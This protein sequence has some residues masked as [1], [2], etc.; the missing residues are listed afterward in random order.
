VLERQKERGKKENNAG[1]WHIHLVVYNLP[2]NL[3]CMIHVLWG[4]GSISVK[5]KSYGYDSAKSAAYMSKYFIKDAYEIQK[6]DK[7]YL[8]SHNLNKP[9][10]VIRPWEFEQLATDYYNQ[11]YV[12]TFI[13]KLFDIPVINNQMKLEVWEPLST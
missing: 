11:G 8:C 1:T 7:V 13:S 4:L 3:R 10:E 12:K 5:R 9:I 6:G 2:Y